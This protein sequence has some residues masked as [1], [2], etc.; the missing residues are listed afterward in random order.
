M[1]PLRK[2][3]ALRRA[4]PG[5][6]GQHG[7]DGGVRRG[8]RRVQEL[9]EGDRQGRFR[10]GHVS[11][12]RRRADQ[13]QARQAHN[14]QGGQRQPQADRQRGPREARA[15]PRRRPEGPG[16]RSRDLQARV[17]GPDRSGG[18]ARDGEALHHPR[19]RREVRGRSDPQAG[20]CPEDQPEAEGEPRRRSPPADRGGPLGAAPVPCHHL[21]R[22]PDLRNTS[23]EAQVRP[24][25]EDPRPEA[26]GKGGTLQVQ[27]VR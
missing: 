4:D 2:A 25:P 26:Q 27:P 14:L 18:S 22:Q 8:H 10:Q 15:R 17:D 5:P 21:L 9:L 23:R 11:L 13:D 7:E 1:Q 6:P 3:H 24:S 20:R 12:L 19:F 16:I